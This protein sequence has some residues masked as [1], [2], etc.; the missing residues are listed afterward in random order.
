[1]AVMYTIIAALGKMLDELGLEMFGNLIKIPFGLEER[2]SDRKVE[3][4]K[5]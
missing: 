1:M 5:Q 4:I 3:K 2:G